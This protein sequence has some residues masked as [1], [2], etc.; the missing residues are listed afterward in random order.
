MLTDREASKY[1]RTKKLMY[2][3]NATEI[4]QYSRDIT[5][6]ISATYI[7]A[8]LKGCEV[9]RISFFIFCPEIY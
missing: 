5:V 7:S 1:H 3:K 6:N 8:G 9:S 4:K 2:T